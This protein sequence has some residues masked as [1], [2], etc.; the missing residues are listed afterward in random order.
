MSHFIDVYMKHNKAVEINEATFYTQLDIW[1][2]EEQIRPHNK[3][4]KKNS[5][6][7]LKSCIHTKDVMHVF[8]TVFK[9]ADKQYNKNRISLRQDKWATPEYIF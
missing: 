5:G 2:A 4:K 1:M 7:N 3:R 8:H 9:S 6:F